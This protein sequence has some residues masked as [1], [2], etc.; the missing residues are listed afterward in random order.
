M[1]PG[2]RFGGASVKDQGYRERVVNLAAHLLTHREITPE[3]ALEIAAK[4]Y[5]VS[6]TYLEAG[7]E[8]YGY[9]K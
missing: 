7:G 4:W 5:E 1:E 3:K 9:L 6:L 2:T 8:K